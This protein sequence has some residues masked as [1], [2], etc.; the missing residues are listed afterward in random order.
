MAARKNLSPP[1]AKTLTLENDRRRCEETLPLRER[2]RLL[3]G[4]VLAHPAT[5]LAADKTFYDE[6]SGDA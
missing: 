3:Q 1:K 4:R 6:L 5:G 2:L